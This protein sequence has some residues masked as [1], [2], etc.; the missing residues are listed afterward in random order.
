MG[1]FV[2]ALF[3]RNTNKTNN[4]QHINRGYDS[5]SGT[6]IQSRLVR[7]VRCNADGHE[8]EPVKTQRNAVTCC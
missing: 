3:E 7:F 2:G 4:K 5:E 8:G 1:A 6:T